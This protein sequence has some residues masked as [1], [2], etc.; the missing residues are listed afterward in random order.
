MRPREGFLQRSA[1]FNLTMSSA[2][3][4]N[5]WGISH[6]NALNIPGIN[7]QGAG[8]VWPMTIMNKKNPSK[9]HG[10]WWDVLV[11]NLHLWFF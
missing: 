11:K 10:Q 6:V 1:R 4:A 7:H 9:L 3:N 8:L 5:R 2:T